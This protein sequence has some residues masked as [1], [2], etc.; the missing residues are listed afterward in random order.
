[1]PNWC[2]FISC[3]FSSTIV[4]AG[5]LVVL[6]GEGLAALVLAAVL[7]DGQALAEAQVAHGQG[8]VGLG[9]PGQGQGRQGQQC[10]GAELHAVAFGSE[11][12]WG[13]QLCCIVDVLFELLW[14]QVATYD[15]ANP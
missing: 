5:L 6:A 3:P 7:Q 13:L 2:S 4:R 12:L 8:A 10:E 11:V 1:M 9:P 14:P 15:G